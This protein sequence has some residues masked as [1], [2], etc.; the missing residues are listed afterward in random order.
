VVIAERKTIMINKR[1]IFNI[2]KWDNYVIFEFGKLWK[3]NVQ[4]Y[5]N[6]LNRNRFIISPFYISWSKS[7]TTSEEVSKSVEGGINFLF[8]NL[9][10]SGVKIPHLKENNEKR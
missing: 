9:F 8:F 5:P 2:G 7:N 3:E 4:N 6:V 1:K 10:V